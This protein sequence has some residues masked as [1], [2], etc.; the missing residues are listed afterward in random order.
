MDLLSFNSYREAKARNYEATFKPWS[1]MSPEEWAEEVYRLPGGRRF[2]WAY[3]PFAKGMFSAIFDKNA[4][5]T[6]YQC[7]SRGFKTT[8]TLLAAGYFIDQSPRRILWMWQTMGH[9]EKFSKEG[10]GAELFDTTPAL[11]FLSSGNRRL[12]SNT[13]TFKQF[14]GGSMNIFGANAPGELRRA[15][16][17]LLIADEID[18]YE[19]NEGDEGDILAIFNKR[20]SE[21]PDTI[22]I[23]ASYPSVLGK[24]RIHMLLKESD[25]QE[26]HVTCVK[27]GGEPFV[28]HRRMLRYE[29]DKPHEARFECP[30][31]AA[32]LT[33]VDRYEMA[34]KQGFNNWKPRN[35]FT[36]RHGFHANAMLW[37]HELDYKKYPGG[38]LQMIAT[39]EIEASKAPD[40]KRATRVFINTF[41][42]EPFDT[43][44]EFERPPEWKPIYDRREDYGLTVP[45]GG[46]FLTCFVD[47]QKNR[48]ELGWR[49]WG[50]ENESWGMDHKII[51]GYTG[52][53][54]VW[55]E[56]IHE[57]RRTWKHE[58]GAIIPLGMAFI[59]G[60]AYAEQVY[61]FFRELAASPV[62]GVYGFV[63]ASKG[64][65]RSPHPI[66]TRGKMQT[67]AGNL[68]GRYIGTWQAKDWI[69]DRLRMSIDTIEGR[70]HYNKQYQQEFFQG[71]VIETATRKFQNGEEFNTYKDE[72]SGNEPLDIEVGCLAACR[73]RA[74]H[75]WDM[76][77]KR[78]QDSVLE[79]KQ[80]AVPQMSMSMGGP[81]RGWS[82]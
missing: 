36:G 40:P 22:Q 71:L 72:V 31:C 63:Q 61:R 57:L 46:L 8:C 67:V 17:N 2:K 60:G 42:A 54:E 50:R 25:Y 9:G 34:H 16:G 77:E 79:K 73:L 80:M 55:K 74:P 24:S 7:F 62:E 68:K 26:W 11:G 14:P 64:V 13:I 41:D 29:K 23:K 47:V 20:G 30:R 39:E 49:A 58:S 75:N 66:V 48:L 56:L 5:E 82:L 19:T 78:L 37:P 51:D 59:D 6:V 27:C 70:I 3:A 81:V 44:D 76:L 45:R 28:M 18:A 15:K 43:T 69:Y 12:S 35:A 52:H 1:R 4:R 53:A 10:L 33:D 38:A 65:G 32:L 21:Y